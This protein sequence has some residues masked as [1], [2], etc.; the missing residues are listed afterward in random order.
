MAELRIAY[1]D[2]DRAPYLHVL[3]ACAGALGLD[4]LLEKAD[5]KTDYPSL[6][7]GGAV[8]VLA[9]NYWGLQAHAAGG[10][11]L[12]SIATTVTHL[13][14]SLFVRPEIAGLD[15]LCGKRLAI[16]GQGPSELIARLWLEEAG[17]ADM[18]GVVISEQDFGRWGNWQAI[19]RDDCHA[20]FVTDFHRREPLEAGLRVLDVPRF[21]FLGNI[22]LTT[23]VGVV[24]TRRRDVA[25]LVRAAHEA[26]RMFREDRERTLSIMRGEP[27]RL[28]GVEDESD[29]ADLYEI[30]RAELAP[31]PVPTV[32]AIRNTYRMRLKTNPELAAF[33]PLLMWD[34]SFAREAA[35]LTVLEQDAPAD[36]AA[37]AGPLLV[38]A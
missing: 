12:V 2:L 7:L 27:R 24:E 22:T 15:D 10:L 33:N 6:L 30:L 31:T 18:D 5:F 34:L 16:R 28:M 9:E 14:E 23:L 4:L 37:S 3:K 35:R 19:V 21:G 1:R 11:P 17:P 25:L 32:D 26:S 29:L 8:D 36:G 38:N 13:N 20:A